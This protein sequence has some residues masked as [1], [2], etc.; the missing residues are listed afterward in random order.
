MRRPTT[1]SLLLLLSACE[2]RISGAPTNL[3]LSDIDA[4][5]P[6]D[7]AVI[8]PDAAMADAAPQLGPW[9]TPRLVS[10]ASTAN[11]E[12][13]VTL[14]SNT[15]ELIFSFAPVG[16]AKHLY[17]T[18]RTTVTGPWA[19]AVALPFNSKNDDET[20]R[21]SA[22]DKT[23]YFASTRAGNG[24][25]DVFTVTRQ[26]AGSTTT[27]TTTPV[28]VTAV[29]TTTRDEKWLA[30]CG[31]DH[32]VMVQSTAAGDTD[33]L[34]GTLGGTAPTAITT[35]NS[36]ANETSAFVT[37]DCLTIYF[38][39]SR[40]TTT[41]LFTAHRTALTAPW[42]APTVVTDFASTGGNQEDPWLSPDGRTFAFASDVSGNKD[43][44]LTTR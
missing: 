9:S 22:D 20:P 38:A 2:A 44:Y 14:S 4:A 42:P 16:G 31:T 21:F 25:L 1:W 26:A 41:K 11:S 28:A 3:G 19:T 30:P 32:Y 5:A 39:S 10:A 40:A 12:D 27:W 35:L 23:L 18:S 43:V 13:D 7:A 36:T 33:L 15:L 24:T 34:E 37:Q 6:S 17:Y 8:E 29:N